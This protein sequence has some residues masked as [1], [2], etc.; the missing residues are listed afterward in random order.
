MA[1]INAIASEFQ[2]KAVL[3]LAKQLNMTP[4]P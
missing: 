1:T 3:A 2:L 4:N